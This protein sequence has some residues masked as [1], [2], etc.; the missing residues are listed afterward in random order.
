MGLGGALSIS[1]GTNDDFN[2]VTGLQLLPHVGYVATDPM[3][4][5]WVRGNLELMLEPALLHLD[6]EVSV[7]TVVGLSAVGRWILD[8][9]PRS[10]PTSTRARGSCWARRICRRPTAT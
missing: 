7:S 10:E 2:T 8:G 3:G 5:G 9:V 4:P 6:T 1:H